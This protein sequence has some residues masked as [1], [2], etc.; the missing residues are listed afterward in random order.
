VCS[1]FCRRLEIDCWGFSNFNTARHD[2]K[3]ITKQEL[4]EAFSPF[5]LNSGELSDYGYGWDLKPFF[6]HATYS[7]SGSIYGFVSGTL[8]FPK[9]GIFIAILSNNTS[10]LLAFTSWKI[11]A[12]LLGE[13]IKPNAKIS[14][15]EPEEY[16]GIY[17]YSDE[18]YVVS[19]GVDG[20]SLDPAFGKGQLL[21][22]RKDELYT[23]ERFME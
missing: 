16:T 9:S 18:R 22:I 5:K 11:S 20:L 19:N 10:S 17:R 4:A 2:G 23:A 15:R 12:I 3:I 6:R 21:Q 8:F 1:F 14:I 13:D 7:H